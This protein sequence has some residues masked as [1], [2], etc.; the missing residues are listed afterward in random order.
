VRRVIVE[1]PMVEFLTKLL[2]VIRSL[3][4]TRARDWRPRFSSSASR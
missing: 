3:F 1:R 4:K 2:L